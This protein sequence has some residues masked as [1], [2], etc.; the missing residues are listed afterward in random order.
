MEYTAAANIFCN[1]LSDT[2]DTNLNQNLNCTFHTLLLFIQN[3]K[4]ESDLLLQNNSPPDC[5]TLHY[6]S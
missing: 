5:K 4:H 6:Q 2:N 1:Q 3:H